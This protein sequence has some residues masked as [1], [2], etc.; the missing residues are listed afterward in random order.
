MPGIQI[1]KN[2]S[3]EFIADRIGF[4]TFEGD[5]QFESI[6]DIKSWC[7]KNYKVNKIIVSP[8]AIRAYS[9][10][11]IDTPQIWAIKY[12]NRDNVEIVTGEEYRN[13]RE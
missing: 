2:N 9:S 1:D 7:S 10:H 11:C 12:I 3:E 4:A 8:K 6:E 13:R 5:D